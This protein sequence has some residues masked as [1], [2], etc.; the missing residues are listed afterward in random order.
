MNFRHS[1]GKEIYDINF[2][3]FDEMEWMKLGWGF[4]ESRRSCKGYPRKAFWLRIRSNPMRRNY[5]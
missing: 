2:I 3:D 5:H 4:T 1:D